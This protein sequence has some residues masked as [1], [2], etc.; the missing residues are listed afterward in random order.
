VLGAA[1]LATLTAKEDAQAVRTFKNFLF[2]ININI[3]ININKKMGQ[4][5]FCSIGVTVELQLHWDNL[6][7]ISRLLK[8]CN[9]EDSADMTAWVPSCFEGSCSD[10]IVQYDCERWDPLLKESKNETQ[11]Y[12]N[13]ESCLAFYGGKDCC[14]SEEYRFIR[15]VCRIMGA[16]ARNISR[17][18]YP[19]TFGQDNDCAKDIADQFDEM[20]E[21]AHRCIDLLVRCGVKREFIKV[22][23]IF[24]LDP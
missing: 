21:R 13:L 9:E 5:A 12:K 16:D 15:F 18:E 22:G 6:E 11:F 3:N 10:E 20:N 7:L 19:T 1:V 2:T 24:S 14:L 17:R 8:Y 23:W 4:D